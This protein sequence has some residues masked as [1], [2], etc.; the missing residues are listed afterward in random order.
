MPEA[1]DEAFKRY[2]EGRSVAIVSRAG[3]LREIAQGHIIDSYDIVVRFHKPLPYIGLESHPPWYENYSH[4]VPT[5][6]QKNVGQRADIFYFNVYNLDGP[7][8]RA[9]S[10]RWFKKIFKLFRKAGGRFLAYELP[11]YAPIEKAG[12]IHYEDRQQFDSKEAE[13]LYSSIL[14]QFSHREMNRL[15]KDIGDPVLVGTAGIQD[16]INNE[17]RSVYV[18]G[19]PCFLDYNL[20]GSERPEGLG[21]KITQ[22]AGVDNLRYLHS[23]PGCVDIRF[24]GVM[25]ELFDRYCRCI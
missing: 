24:D 6:L 14:H 25:E 2:I 3:Y 16:I 7:D 10:L 8:E 19:F 12:K 15:R 9:P 17:P 23:L 4:F 21:P 5:D 20:D 1:V 22:K 11:N 18:T 13:A